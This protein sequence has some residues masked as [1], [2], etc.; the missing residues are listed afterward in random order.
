M[1]IEHIKAY[2]NF[3]EKWLAG[4]TLGTRGKTNISAHIRRWL[5][6][7]RGEKCESCGWAERHPITKKVPVEIH[8][9]D[10]K[11]DSNKPENLQLL[12]PNCHSLTKT[13]RNLNENSGRIRR[14]SSNVERRICNATVGGSSPSLGSVF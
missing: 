10:G 4:L 7:T 5:I 12:C 14:G 3:V 9:I 6:E 2:Q 13:F 11:W 8:H 1:K